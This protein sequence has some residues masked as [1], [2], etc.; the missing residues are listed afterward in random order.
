[1]SQSIHVH[2]HSV[3]CV[4]ANRPIA[5]KVCVRDTNIILHGPLHIILLNECE[6]PIGL[7][8]ARGLGL[9]LLFA[10]GSIIL[11]EHECKG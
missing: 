1:M 6:H 5:L 3:D 7:V 8:V 4:L 11:V 10:D 2:W 9:L